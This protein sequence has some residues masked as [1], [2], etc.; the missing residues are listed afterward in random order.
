MTMLDTAQLAPE[1]RRPIRRAE[2]DAMGE[3]GL[4]LDERVELID[5]VIVRMS[6]RTV[7]HDSVLERLYELLGPKLVGRTR[8]RIQLAFAA[9]EWSEPEPDF[10]LVPADE[11]RTDH[12]S[13][14]HLV[15]EVA[16][17][18]F[19]FDR[20]TKAAMYARAGVPHYWIV[21]AEDRSVWMYS[22]PSEDGYRQNTH[23]DRAATLEVPGFEDV[24]LPV[25]A[26]FS[27]ED[28]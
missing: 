20:T 3:A 1:Q 18:S 21:D 7:L 17:S 28:P 4:F 6:P 8:V 27:G 15:V 12:P 9:D 22:A 23:C 26:L 5:G 11:A 25:A 2:Y 24:L 14:A 19:R 10:A 13:R 16:V